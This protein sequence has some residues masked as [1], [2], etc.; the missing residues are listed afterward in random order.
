MKNIINFLFEVGMLK[1][2]PR[3]GYQFLGSGQESVAEHSFR[4]AIIGYVLSLQ[5]PEADSRKI[6]LMCLFHDLHEARTGDHNYVNK[7]YVTVD[8]ESAVKDLAREIPFGA[9]IISIT[10]EF[11][12]GE[13]PEAHISRDADQLDLILELKE[14]QDLGNGYAKE[15]LH[16]AVQ[17]ITTES[18]RKM[19]Q[20]ILTTDSTDWW[21]DKKTDLWVNGPANNKKPE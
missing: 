9:D 6:T 12:E 11:N 1:K 8:E 14:Q 19:A 10:R 13:S 3:T 15:W 18:G 2:T 20:E 16:Y 7:R 17:R 5:E 4:T 21:F